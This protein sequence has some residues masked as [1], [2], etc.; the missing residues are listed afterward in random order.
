MPSA[1]STIY[2][3][4]T[5]IDQRQAKTKTH[6]PRHPIIMHR[7]PSGLTRPHFLNTPTYAELVLRVSPRS[8][9]DLLKLLFG[10][11]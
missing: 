4:H 5:N 10:A 6:Q 9:E 7:Y 11:G 8:Y 1:A 2:L 3:V